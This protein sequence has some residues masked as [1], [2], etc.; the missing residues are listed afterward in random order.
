MLEIAVEILREATGG[1]TRQ[2]TMKTVFLNFMQARQYLAL[3]ISW[4]FL[5]Y[6]SSRKIFKTTP[7]GTAFLE[8]YENVSMLIMTR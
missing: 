8:A 6:Q 5:E 4:G 7:K 3:L 1:T 2:K